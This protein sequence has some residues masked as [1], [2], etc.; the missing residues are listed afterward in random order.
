MSSITIHDLD[1][2]L[3][4]KLTEE[5]R[6]SRKS[7]NQVVKDFLARALGM[8]V[9]G[10][11]SDDYGEFCGRWSEDELKTFNR[12]QAENSKIDATDWLQ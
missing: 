5:A 4:R 9:H 10:R 2:E 12:L 3:D 1:H 7:K 11:Y 8:Q 6:R